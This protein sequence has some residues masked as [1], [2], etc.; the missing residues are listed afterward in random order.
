LITLR[1]EPG[2]SAS[3]PFQN[4]KLHPGRNSGMEAYLNSKSVYGLGE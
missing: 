4:Q 1:A 3:C 2:S